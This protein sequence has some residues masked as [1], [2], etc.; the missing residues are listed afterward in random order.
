[1]WVWRAIWW[2]SKKVVWS[3]KE[4]ILAMKT[5][6]KHCAGIETVKKAPLKVPFFCVLNSVC[7]C[8]EWAASSR[9]GSS[10]GSGWK[11][12]RSTVLQLVMLGCND[13]V[14][15][16]TTDTDASLHTHVSTMFD[17]PV[18]LL[19]FSNT[20]FQ[21]SRIDSSSSSG[22]VFFTPVFIFEDQ[23]LATL[24]WLHNWIDDKKEREKKIPLNHQH[25]RGEK[26]KSKH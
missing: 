13:P 25:S 21:A 26:N 23:I 2:Y 8:L 14:V 18:G 4:E 22:F 5:Y 6:E 15:S 12:T 7:C 16:F 3:K 1:M 10:W 17:N 11:T 19:L 20:G 24:F 9:Q